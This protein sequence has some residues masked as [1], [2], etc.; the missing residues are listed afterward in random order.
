MSGNRFKNELWAFVTAAGLGLL[1]VVVPPAAGED[2][3]A[4]SQSVMKTI[5]ERRLVRTVQWKY[6]VLQAGEPIGSEAVTRSDYSD[7]SVQFESQ[8]EL[9]FQHGAQT[10]IATDLL[11]E[12]ET[13]F[14]IRFEITRNTKQGDVEFAI[15]SHLEWFSN[16]AAVY[17][18]SR[19]VSDTLHVVLPAGAAVVDMNVAHHLSIPLYWYDTQRGGVQN[20]NVVDPISAKIYPAT[21]RL[22][23]GETIT[24]KGKET[25]TERYE[26]TREKLTFKVYVDAEGRIVKLDQG[27]LVYELSEWSEK[28]VG[29]E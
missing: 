29:E 25:P 8:V 2:P 27:F 7:N 22:Q 18:T 5:E 21:L 6:D 14:P 13:F 24:V 9:A 20:F 28:N 12:E 23:T 10:A 1:A 15:G 11:L 4:P 26:F 17:K 3:S 19:G 16:V